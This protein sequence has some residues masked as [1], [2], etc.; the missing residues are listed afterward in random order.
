MVLDVVGSSPTSRPKKILIYS[1]CAA[2]LQSVS[3][4]LQIPLPMRILLAED[5][6]ADVYLVREALAAYG[7]EHDLSVVDDGEKA[8]EFLALTDAD[9]ERPSPQLLL[10]D[11]NL[12]RR[13]GLEILRFLRASIRSAAIPVIVLTSS[14]SPQDRARVAELGVAHYFC[15]P[16]D[17]DAFMR[18]GAIVAEAVR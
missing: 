16:S 14:D 15:K 3:P 4:G 9:A 13:S 5:N 18:L 8:I 7:V 1:A 11:L 6:A 12:P 2:R 17:F 10:L